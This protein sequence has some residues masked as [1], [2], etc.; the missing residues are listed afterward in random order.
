MRRIGLTGGIATGKSHVLARFREHGVPVIDADVLARESVAPGSQG[1]AG[2]V[3][4][5]GP[6]ILR[7]DGSLDRAAL[8]AIV[9][10]DATARRDLEAIVH[11]YVRQRIEAF[12]AAIPSSVPF[13]VADIPLLYESSREEGFDAVVVVACARER[14]LERVMARDGLSREDAER[15]IASQLPIEEKVKR[16]DHVIRTDGTYADTDAQVAELLIRLQQAS[17]GVGR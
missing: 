16:A 13:A 2:A 5:F 12:F 17:G 8:G 9:F 15:R 14:Q 4:R 11:P 10:R 3:S 1:L 7:P 6:E